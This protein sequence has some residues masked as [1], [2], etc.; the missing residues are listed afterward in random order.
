[1]FALQEF[2]AAGSLNFKHL[3][4]STR[5]IIKLLGISLF[6]LQRLPKL[7]NFYTRKSRIGWIINSTCILT[8]Q[9]QSK[10]YSMKVFFKTL[11]LQ[12]STSADETKHY[13]CF[14]YC[15]DLLRRLA[16]QS[17]AGST[18][19]SANDF[20]YKL[21]LV[22][23]GDIG[24]EVSV[25]AGEFWSVCWEGEKFE[26]EQTNASL[27]TT[28]HNSCSRTSWNPSGRPLVL[29]PEEKTQTRRLGKFSSFRTVAINDCKPMLEQVYCNNIKYAFNIHTAYNCFV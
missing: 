20:H 24:R 7:S 2:N 19:K 17:K 21:H 9:F 22:G 8:K 15:I 1:M 10:K 6:P 13:C 26:S 25:S 18:V 4:I 29:A 14:G 12:W 5:H 16:N 11:T 27:D 28:R 3:P 23:D